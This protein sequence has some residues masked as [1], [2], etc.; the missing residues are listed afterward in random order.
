MMLA[1][2]DGNFAVI[3]VTLVIAIGELRPDIT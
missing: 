2:K 1:G 3:D